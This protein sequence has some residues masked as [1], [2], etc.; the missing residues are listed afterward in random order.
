MWTK[1]KAWPGKFADPPFPT[2]QKPNL[3]TLA[4]AHAAS[5]QPHQ[6]VIPSAP[7][8]GSVRK[9]FAGH[10]VGVVPE[11][12]LCSSPAVAD[13]NRITDD[14]SWSCS[15]VVKMGKMIQ[16][17][18]KVRMTEVNFPDRRWKIW[19]ENF[20]MSP[21]GM[22]ELQRLAGRIGGLNE[23][24]FGREW[25]GIWEIW[26]LKMEWTLIEEIGGFDENGRKRKNLRCRYKRK[27]CLFIFSMRKCIYT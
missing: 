8:T 17:A 10:D 2:S 15:A 18:K 26:E 5:E 9:H 16:K 1:S 3:A 11:H 14:S 22:S 20:A 7:H 27:T 4:P 24:S 6:Y 25:G 13:G 23:G 19:S 12:I 21:W